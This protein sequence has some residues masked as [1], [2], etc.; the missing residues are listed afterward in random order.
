MSKLGWGV[1]A[2]V[3]VLVTIA[4]I[5]LWPPSDPLAHVQT[6]AVQPLSGTNPPPADSSQ[7]PPLVRGLEIALNDHHIRVVTDPDAADAIIAIEFD[8]ADIHLEKNGI[9]ATAR[10]LITKKNG[11][12]GVLFLTLNIDQTG[13]H[14]YLVERKFW[15]FW[16]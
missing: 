6:V 7:Q 11:E 4:V 5:L 13:M 3:V 14:A 10:C 2:I 1:T 16:K 15:E 9:Q 12:R 8:K